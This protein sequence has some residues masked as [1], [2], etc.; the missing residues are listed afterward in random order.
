[1]LVN[2]IDRLPFVQGAAPRLLGFVYSI[3]STVHGQKIQDPNVPLVIM[4]VKPQWD[5]KASTLYQ[6]VR[7]QYVSSKDT[8]VLGDLVDRDLGY[9]KIGDTVKI[10][11]KDKYG[12]DVT[13]RLVIVGIS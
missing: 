2:W 12:Q 13:K 4:G 8:I 3:N 6:T 11:L 10:K 1:M 9:P 7:G 5:Q